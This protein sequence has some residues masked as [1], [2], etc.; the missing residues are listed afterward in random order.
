MLAVIRNANQIVSKPMAR[1]ISKIVKYEI[2][3]I[4]LK[5]LTQYTRFQVIKVRIL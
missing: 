1:D 4:V 5:T 2:K 3:Q